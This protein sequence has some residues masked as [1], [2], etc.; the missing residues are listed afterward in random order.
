L[1]ETSKVIGRLEVVTTRETVRLLLD[2]TSD[3]KKATPVDTGWAW[4]NWIP[5]LGSQIP[6]APV[7]TRDNVQRG[8]SEAG[9]GEVLGMK[10]GDDSYLVNNVPYIENLN[11]GSSPKADAGYVDA[12]IVARVIEANGKVLE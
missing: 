11:E 8:A 6:S 10:P 2:I 12:A 1:S 9:S 4:N 5:G 3:V 7:G